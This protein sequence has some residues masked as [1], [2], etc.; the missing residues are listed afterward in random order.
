MHGGQHLDPVGRDIEALFESSQS[1]VTGLVHVLYRP[2]VAF[3]EG[4]TSPHSLMT[5]SKGVYGEA[6]GEWTPA[7][8]LGF[9]KMLSLTGAFWHRADGK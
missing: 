9:S 7:D 3:V 1:R 8:A 2:G 6:V 4:V 5:V